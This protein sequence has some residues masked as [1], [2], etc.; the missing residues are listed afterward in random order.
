MER[1]IS[2]GRVWVDGQPAH[3]GMRVGTTH[4]IQVDGQALSFPDATSAQ[5]HLLLYHKPVGEICSRADP[6]GRPTVFD[7][8]PEGR[9]I[10]VGRLDLNTS[11]LLLFSDDGELANQL[12]HPRSGIEREY[13]V[14]V[15]G[16]VDAAM[17]E[18]L[19]RGVQ[20]EDGPAR[21]QA[22][23]PGGGSGAN[24]WYRVVTGEGRNRLVRRLWE[25]QGVQVSRL[26]RI[27]FGSIRLPRELAAGQWRMLE[28]SLVAEIQAQLTRD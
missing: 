2:E 11:G 7:P 19:L 22:I 20:L 12:M 9:W 8:L 17:R 28:D 27:R 14:R 4:E 5:P 13:S 24:R 6:G 3:L 23:Q 18:R 16:E 21:F 15:L 1:L 26:V 10:S 25:S